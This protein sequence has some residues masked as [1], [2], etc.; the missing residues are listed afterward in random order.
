MGAS[1]TP[2]QRMGSRAP[3]KSSPVK[4][5]SEDYNTLPAPSD[6][7]GGTTNYNKYCTL[8]LYS[9]ALCLDSIYYSDSINNNNY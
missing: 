4:I 5:S 6:T 1:A 2:S 7:A 8:I 9:K 3:G